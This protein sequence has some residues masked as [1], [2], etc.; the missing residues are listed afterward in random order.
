MS[1][2]KHAGCADCDIVEFLNSHERTS[3]AI[4]CAVSNIC[5]IRDSDGPDSPLSPIALAG[6]ALTAVGAKTPVIARNCVCDQV[7]RAKLGFWPCTG[8]DSTAAAPRRAPR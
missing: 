2:E 4:A 1:P 3:G 8:V 7:A 6:L 5:G